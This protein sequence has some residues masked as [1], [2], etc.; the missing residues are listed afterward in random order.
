MKMLKSRNR[1]VGGD[2]ENDGGT[3]IHF[4]PDFDLPPGVSLPG[5]PPTFKDVEEE[6]LL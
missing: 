5:T 1:N 2:D 3:P 6:V 4:T